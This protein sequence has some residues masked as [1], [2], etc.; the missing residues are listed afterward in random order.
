MS[1]SCMVT[2]MTLSE[3]GKSLLKY[4]IVFFVSYTF[5]L[6]MRCN[7]LRSFQ[8]DLSYGTKEEVFFFNFNSFINE[9][10]K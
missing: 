7:P 8:G 10:D 6:K 2:R 4:V 3:E 1:D 5:S 9:D